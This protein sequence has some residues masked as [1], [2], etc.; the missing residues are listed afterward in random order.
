M[1]HL[2][3]IPCAILTGQSKIKYLS[4]MKDAT[5]LAAKSK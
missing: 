3:L 1:T 4:Y 5:G 2:D